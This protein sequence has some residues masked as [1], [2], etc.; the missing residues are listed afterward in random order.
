MIHCDLEKCVGCRMCEVA[1]SSFHFG[2]VSPAL[3]RI[4]VS[5]LEDIGIDM[6]V[7]CYSCVEKP[8]LECPTDAL[9]VG[10][11]GEIVLDEDLC[12]ACG[13]CVDACPVGACGDDGDEPL[14]CDLCGGETTCVS[15][16]PTDALSYRESEE[17]SLAA[18]L[19]NK[20]NANQR[21]AGYVNVQ[22]KPIREKWM[23]G[24]RVDS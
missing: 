22:A 14:F 21:R 12:G 20:G 3:S 5:K 23:T 18:F 1:C 16:C 4:H 13:I 24:G 19:D 17:V 7:A 10:P 8:C 6:A 15:E 11:K 2:A 9:S